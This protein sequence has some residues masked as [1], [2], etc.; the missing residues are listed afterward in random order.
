M[1]HLLPC[2]SHSVLHIQNILLSRFNESNNSFYCYF[3]PYEIFGKYALHF[4]FHSI[5]TQTCR[6]KVSATTCSCP[7]QP[8]RRRP[9]STGNSIQHASP[10]ANSNAFIPSHSSHPTSLSHGRAGRL[11][12]LSHPESVLITVNRTSL[13]SFESRFSSTC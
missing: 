2:T 11:Q 6:N 12:N 7:G 1:S 4:A 13:S 10:A 5:H 9:W 8:G 3:S